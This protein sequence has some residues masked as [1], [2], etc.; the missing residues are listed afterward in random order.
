MCAQIT[1]TACYILMQI[2]QYHVPVPYSSTMVKMVMDLL[3]LTAIIVIQ[4]ISLIMKITS[5]QAQFHIAPLYGQREQSLA[6]VSLRVTEASSP[7]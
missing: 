6:A 4:L 5:P 2:E 3:Q 7:V 1:Y